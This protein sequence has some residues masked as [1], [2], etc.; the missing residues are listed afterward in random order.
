MRLLSTVAVIALT[1]CSL[2]AIEGAYTISGQ[3][4]YEKAPYTGTAVITK[5]GDVYQ[6]QWSFDDKEKYVGTGLKNGNEV[7]FIF[8]KDDKTLSGVQVYKIDGTTLSGPWVLLGKSLIGTEK[9]QKQ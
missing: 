4:P 6:G 9:M 8:Q 5:E 1:T 7:S 2:F 3:D